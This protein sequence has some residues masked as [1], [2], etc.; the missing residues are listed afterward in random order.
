MGDQI[1]AI[2]Q[3]TNNAM[4]KL[5]K[6]H[7]AYLQALRVENVAICAQLLH[8]GLEYSVP[9]HE[10]ADHDQIPMVT[11]SIQATSRMFPTSLK[12]PTSSIDLFETL[13]HR[14]N[15]QYSTSRP[16]N[17]TFVSLVNL[18]QSDDKSLRKI[19]SSTLLDAQPLKDEL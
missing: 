15:T 13:V 17:I 9:F 8:G 12:G 3:T 11:H 18:R 7:E 5:R 16:H 4:E 10:E 1:K 14:F 6:T 19:F 2:R